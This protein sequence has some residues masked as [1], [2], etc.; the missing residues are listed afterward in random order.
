MTTTDETRRRR[1][2]NERIFATVLVL[3]LTAAVAALIRF[4]QREERD[5]L[6]QMYVPRPTTMTPEVAL[7]QEYIR[8][9]T[10]NPPGNEMPAAQWLAGQL[11]R[12]GIRAEIIESAPRRGSV[13]A[14][15]RGRQAGEGLL[16]VH[17]IDVVPA[18]PEGWTRPP[19]SGEIHQN[20][21]YG[22]GTL[23][24]KGLGVCEL[25]AFIAVARGGRQ[26]ERDLVFLAVADEET[27][28]EYGMRWILE[29]RPDVIEGVRYAINEGGIT[30]MMQERVTYY[31]IEINTKQT[32]RV[33]VNAP[34]REQLLKARIAL[35]PWF[36]RREPDR[37]LPEVRRLFREIA[38]QRVAFREY[39]EDIDRTIAIGK[40][41]NLP[42]GYREL[43]QNNVWT[44][45]ISQT[46]RGFEMPVLLFNIPDELPLERVRW[47]REKVAS[48]GARIAE[49]FEPLGPVPSSSPDTP[50]FA[51]LAREAGA[52]FR[53]P[54]GTEF[55]ARSVSDSRFLR[56]KGIQAY[57]INAF[58]VDFF[59]SESI[60]GVN[61]RLR[62]DYFQ[63][64][65]VFLNRVVERYA[66][67][68]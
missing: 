44:E 24:N 47:L 67:A 5:I 1:H 41:W 55:M 42:A 66:F 39:L 36:I 8:I 17:H 35:E 61:E 2:R 54:A 13:Y 11:A 16:L 51:L 29:H 25:A 28:S 68:N 46:E 60:H 9:D 6:D 10:S 40:F 26:P 7:L 14:R 45:P 49:P 20:Q 22:R 31:G 3:V 57:G 4:S 38:P 18:A 30:E 48:S 65:V 53:A 58:P 62:V 32:V 34:S 23:D 27:G 19:F 56:V 33:V 21:L 37:I 50:F 59:Q 63:Q 64:G 43:V 12:N 52:A 15:I